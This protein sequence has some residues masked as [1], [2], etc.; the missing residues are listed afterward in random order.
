MFLVDPFFVGRH[1]VGYL[2]NGTMFD[3]SYDRGQP[4]FFVFGAGHVIPGW[5]T[6]LPLLSKG[7]KARI[8]VAPEVQNDGRICIVISLRVLIGALAVS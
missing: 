1:Y 5:E 8:T 7:E 6:V 3:N 4:I 2:E